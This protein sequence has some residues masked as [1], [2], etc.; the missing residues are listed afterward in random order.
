MCSFSLGVFSKC[1]MEL[2]G[3][4]TL[5]II[6]CH[7]PHY[8]QMPNWLATVLSN[9]GAGCDV[10]LFLSGMGMYNSYTN[11][12]LKGYVVLSWYWK[13]YVRIIIPCAFFIMGIMIYHGGLSTVSIPYLIIDIFGF[14]YLTGRSALWYVSCALLLYLITPIVHKPLT[15]KTR[16]VWLCV[17]CLLSL[18]FWYVDLGNSSMIR[19]WQFCVSRFPSYFIGYS[20]AKD[21]KE[22]KESNICLF[23]LLPLVMYSIFFTLNHTIG[24][25]FSLFWT[26]GIPIMTICAL[27]LDWMKSSAIRKTLSF[28][29]S[30]S[31]ESYA[32]NVLILP[33]FQLL[34]FYVCGVNTNPNNITFY[35]VGT[36]ICVFLSIV[37]NKISRYIITCIS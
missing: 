7:S 36:F 21:I 16:W 14:L 26:Q 11:H 10:F 33:S 28:M 32:T 4:A 31:L 20:L 2:M 18:A 8:I 37:V 19:N 27:F 15:G 24:T 13:R 9:G 35:I 1:R 25:N 23:V 34:P 22:N 30:I 29:G 3:I 5:M 17:L 6:V 12:K